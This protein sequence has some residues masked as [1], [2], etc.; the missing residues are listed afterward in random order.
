MNGVYLYISKSKVDNLYRSAKR[1]QPLRSLGLKLKGPFVEADANLQ[2]DAA[3]LYRMLSSVKKRLSEGEEVPPYHSLG[4]TSVPIV[5]FSG[6]AAMAV[7]GDTFSLALSEDTTALL[8]AGSTSNMVGA[9][10]VPAADASE[11][12]YMSA[13]LNPVGALRAALDGAG[14]SQTLSRELSFGWQALRRD[15]GIGS[16]ILRNVRGFAIFAGSYPANKAQL[17]RAGAGNVTSIVV[18]SPIYVEQ[19]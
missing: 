6:P 7:H 12:T 19:I 16:A 3:G 18:A 8:L 15:A 11:R 2:F 5:S 4:E 10:P 13:S 9:P 1:G 14:E 17:R